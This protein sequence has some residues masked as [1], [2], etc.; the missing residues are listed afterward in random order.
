[1]S[2]DFNQHDLVGIFLIEAKDGLQALLKAASPADGSLPTPAGLRDQ[3]VLAHRVKGAA[4]QYGFAGIAEVGEILE[5]ILEHIEDRAQD[6]W[7]SQVALIRDLITKMT[8][9]VDAIKQHE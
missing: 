4:S 9:Q 8:E 2:N 6:N 5:T 7:A 1:M 3:Y